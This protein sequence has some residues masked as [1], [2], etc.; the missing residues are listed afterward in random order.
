MVFFFFCLFSL[1]TL[2]FFLPSTW[3][4]LFVP[5]HMLL[6]MPP[7]ATHLGF[8]SLLLVDSRGL[9]LVGFVCVFCLFRLFVLGIFLERE[10]EVWKSIH[11][12]QSSQTR[13]RFGCSGFDVYGIKPPAAHFTEKEKRA[14]MR[15]SQTSACPILVKPVTK[16][17]SLIF[18]SCYTWQVCVRYPHETNEKGGQMFQKMKKTYKK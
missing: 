3:F 9:R 11:S 5:I 2:S 4:F 18:V 17:F 10:D 14:H 6:F 7:L 15:W 12:S 16:G 13:M 8:L 1:P